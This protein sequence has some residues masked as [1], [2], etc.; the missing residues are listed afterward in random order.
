MVEAPFWMIW[1]G[2][3]AASAL[4]LFL[5]AMPFLYAARKPVHDCVRA[6]G[7]LAGGPLRLVS[8][9]LLA[10]AHDMRERNRAVLLA[11]G[12]EE[13]GTLIAR[14]FERVAVLV[15]RDLE[16]YPALQRRLLD[17][18]TKV[19]ED[20]KKSG[21]V[22]PPPPE[23]VEAVEAVAKVKNGNELVQRVLDEINRSIK[24]IHEK[25]LGEYRNAYESRHK[26]LNSFMPFW[27][28][29]DKT[30]A[31]ADRK[32][33]SLND[34][35][36]QIDA[37]MEKYQQIIKKTE[38][39]EHALTVSQMTQF[40][41]STLVLAIAAGGALINYKLIALPMSEMVGAGDYLTA[42][43]RTS[44]VAAL[45]IIFVEATMGLFLMETLRITHLFPRIHNL[46]DEMRRRMMWI[47]LT[48]LV[49][50]AGIEAALALMRDMLIADKAALLQSLAAT[51]HAIAPDG[52]LGRIPTAGQMLL[53]F[54]LPFA[55]AF[56]AIP[57][58]S[59]V[60]SVR[61]VGGAA[62][63]M[64]ARA[65]A[66][67]LRLTGNLVR[68]LARVLITLYDIV[69]VVPLLI[70]RLLKG[71]TVAPEKAKHGPALD[72]EELARGRL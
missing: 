24:E 68:N 34:R 41:V 52:L 9:W 50:L 35:A 69:I 31:Q 53:G 70:E 3:A 22:P 30:L 15:R 19:E 27:R 29:L 54:I 55:L 48:L 67:L 64:L 23:W 56:V 51:T 65:A 1:P 14:E 57:L 60:S 58:E 62:L 40:F 42:S 46:S 59:F 11:H 36:A 10:A 37:Q 43:L 33:T 5:I 66:F 16:G 8:R 72:D 12:R 17:E 38:K 71:R 63:V 21:E 45:V 28:S 49:T 39:V 6:I 44:D 18:I 47:A 13:T 32:M 2:N 61:T 20:Y 4:V 26:I 25:M 7:H